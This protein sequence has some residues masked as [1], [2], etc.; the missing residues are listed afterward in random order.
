MQRMDH[1]SC[2]HKNGTY[3]F[4][5]VK[6][7]NMGKTYKAYGINKNYVKSFSLKTRR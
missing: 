2:R 6:E 5:Q 3:L 1:N 4:G 7:N